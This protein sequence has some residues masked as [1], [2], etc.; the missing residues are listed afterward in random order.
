MAP[1]KDG[2][3]KEKKRHNYLYATLRIL[4]HDISRLKTTAPFMQKVELLE[5]DAKNKESLAREEQARPAPARRWGTGTRHDEELE[6]MNWA[7]PLRHDGELE[8][9]NWATPLEK[10]WEAAFSQE[11]KGERHFAECGQGGELIQQRTRNGQILDPMKAKQ[12]DDICPNGHHLII[13]RQNVEFCCDKCGSDILV[14]N[15]MRLCISCDFSIC[16]PGCSMRGTEN[17]PDGWKDEGEVVPKR[18]RFFDG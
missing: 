18:R 3:V 5:G 13:Q 14:G 10:T 15:Q 8:W 11:V 1:A 4:R 17:Q 16:Y 2:S 6:R 9:M 12:S 7:T